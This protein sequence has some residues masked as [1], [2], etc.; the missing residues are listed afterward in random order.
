MA[1]G[2]TRPV[3]HACRCAADVRPQQNCA[4]LMQLLAPAR[5]PATDAVRGIGSAARTPGNSTRFAARLPLWSRT[6]RSQHAEA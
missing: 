1:Q 5:R 6:G 3:G 4:L 2:I